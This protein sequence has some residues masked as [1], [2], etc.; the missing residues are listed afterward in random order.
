M[1]S[2]KDKDKKKAKAPKGNGGISDNVVSVRHLSHED[3]ELLSKANIDVNGQILR[4]TFGVMQNND[5][6]VELYRRMD[7][8][9][10]RLKSQDHVISQLIRL[11]AEI[12]CN[13]IWQRKKAPQKRQ[14]KN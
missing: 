1:S 9:E 3:R 13:R 2:S 10:K 11:Q 7:M 4:L 12:K 6:A 8:L 14:V 5:N